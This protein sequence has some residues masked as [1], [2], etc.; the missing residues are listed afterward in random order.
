MAVMDS[1]FLC[2]FVPVLGR[3]YMTEEMKR[4]YEATDPGASRLKKGVLLLENTVLYF[5]AGFMYRSI[6]RACSPKTTSARPALL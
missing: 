5:L 1:K 6:D 2:T 3:F 4:E